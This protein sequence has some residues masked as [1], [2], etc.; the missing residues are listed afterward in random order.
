MTHA[1]LKEVEQAKTKPGPT[2]NQ[3]V[4]FGARSS[5]L[6]PKSPTTGASQAPRASTAPRA[7]VLPPRPSVAP[8]ARTSVGPTPSK[9][10]EKPLP[11]PSM[12]VGPPM[13][14]AELDRLIADLVH[15]VS[16]L[17]TYLDASA[18]KSQALSGASESL[19][20]K[21]ASVRLV[22]EQL[23]TTL[24]ACEPLATTAPDKRDAKRSLPPASAADAALVP[25]RAPMA[26]HPGTVPPA[27][28]VM[29][30]DAP[31]PSRLSCPVALAKPTGG[32]KA[33]SDREPSECLVLTDADLIVEP[34]MEATIIEPEKAF[35]LTQPTWLRTQQAEENEAPMFPRSSSAP[36]ERLSPALTTQAMMGACPKCNHVDS[37]AFRFCVC[38][39]YRMESEPGDGHGE[40]TPLESGKFD[41]Q[42][43]RGHL[44]SILTKILRR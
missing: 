14:E 29:D 34:D 3:A 44:A 9:A 43:P 32:D 40:P 36:P 41:K 20:R 7:S 10:S 15:S 30:A 21:L 35:L 24:G 22:R 37:S 42:T 28:G 33:T 5:L 6:P 26:T 18:A 19:R 12:R 23:V 1:A 16:R 11:R 13:N 39:G 2:T 17:E 8:P 38:C 27:S 31:R 25:A 4:Q